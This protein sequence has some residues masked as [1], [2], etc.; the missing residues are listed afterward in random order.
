MRDYLICFL[1]AIYY[2]ED[3]KLALVVQ[4]LWLAGCLIACVEAL[5]SALSFGQCVVNGWL[6]WCCLPRQAF[7]RRDVGVVAKARRGGPLTS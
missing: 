4:G 7:V 2:L 3:N 5:A 1:W 6:A